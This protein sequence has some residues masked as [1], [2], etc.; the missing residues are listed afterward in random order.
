M[1]LSIVLIL[2]VVVACCVLPMFFM[3]RK[4]GGTKSVEKPGD[5]SNRP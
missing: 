1:N 3:M 5:G 4:R 2:G